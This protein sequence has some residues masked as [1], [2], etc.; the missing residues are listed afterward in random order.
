[1]SKY[2]YQVNPEALA[3][4]VASVVGNKHKACYLDAPEGKPP[5]LQWYSWSPERLWE[6]A[7]ETMVQDA[8]IKVIEGIGKNSVEKKLADPK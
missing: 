1:M 8:V 6:Q 4:I 7:V 2:K 5:P 3:S